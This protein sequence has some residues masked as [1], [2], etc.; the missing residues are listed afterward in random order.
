MSFP[1]IFTFIM[2]F[3]SLYVSIFFLGLNFSIK[4]NRRYLY[5]SALCFAVFLYDLFSALFYNALNSESAVWLQRG[6]F[7]SIALISIFTYLFIIQEEKG[8]ISKLDIGILSIYSL[9][10]FL[11]WIPGKLLLTSDIESTK[12]L[13]SLSG[14]IT[15]Y[16]SS[17]GFLLMI[18][19]ILIV[20]SIIY[21][22]GILIAGFIK[23]K[24]TSQAIRIIAISTFFM[25]GVNDILI[26]A[27]VIRTIYLTEYAFFAIIILMNY[28]LI[29]R[30]VNVHR[31]ET[32]INLELEEKV[33]ERT[34]EIMILNNEM[35]QTNQELKRK[36]EI[37]KHL[38]EKDGLTG[39]MNHATFMSRLKEI[40]NM[41][42]RFKFPLSIVMIDVDDFKIVN[43]QY[44]HQVGDN[45]L[46]TIASLFRINIAQ[47]KK[48]TGQKSI[49]SYDLAARYGGDEFALILPYCDSNGTSS[50]INRLFEQLKIIGVEGYDGSI[51]ISCGAVSTEKVETAG[52]LEMIK[53]ADEA[54]YLAKKQGKG[55]FVIF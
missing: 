23:K 15:I 38:A 10:I 31:R 22:F 42:K 32:I 17:P 14:K 1:G 19:Y 49:R 21:V 5:F 7:S 40:L 12:I 51:S 34:D 48:E 55:C 20:L 3:I 27:S 29:R 33:I 43:D 44:G 2:G 46:Q 16:E 6:Q 30:F 25:A 9:F 35:T 47:L 11:P 37:L 13:N 54:L 18:E 36:N 26:G 39:L 52:I 50:I 28:D 8:T 45:M 53:Y 4:T 41:S 24:K